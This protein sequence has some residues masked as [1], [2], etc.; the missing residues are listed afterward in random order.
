MSQF[1]CEVCDD[2]IELLGDDRHPPEC[3]C[4][5]EMVPTRQE[6]CVDQDAA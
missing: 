2:V 3:A 5:A 1:I 6:A 4:G